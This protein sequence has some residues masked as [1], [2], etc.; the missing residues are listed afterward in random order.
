MFVSLRC[1]KIKQDNESNVHTHNMRC[2]KNKQNNIDS[3][4]SE[5]N[6]VLMGSEKTIHSI[7]EKIDSLERTKKLRSDETRVL[8]FVLSASPEYFYDFDK[9]GMS[10]EEWDKLVPGQPGT[11]EKIQAVKDTLKAGALKKWQNES[12]EF[13]KEQEE[14]KGNIVN[15]ILHMDEKTPHIHL[16]VTPIM[17]G[18]L[19]AKKFFTPAS[20]KRWQD[21][22]AKKL[23]KLGLKRGIPSE[24]VHTSLKQRAY[25]DG[26]Q[27]GF[28]DGWGLG[29]KTSFVNKLDVYE[30]SKNDALASYAA[31]VARVG[32]LKK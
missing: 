22:Y 21:N 3:S 10:R 29:Q 6:K 11:K 23:S 16:L 31:S 15:V 14:F 4:Y 9:V 18:R 24:K 25:E 12:I 17:D 2:G 13:I 20:A 28:N 19:S 26:F 27:A 7:N 32:T 8:E 30:Q 5:F 1:Q